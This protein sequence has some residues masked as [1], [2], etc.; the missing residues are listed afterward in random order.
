MGRDEELKLFMYNGNL[1][2]DIHRKIKIIDV[3]DD[4]KIIEEVKSRLDRRNGLLTN[5]QCAP[6]YYFADL[7]GNKISD[8]YYSIRQIG[9][10]K[11]F[12]VSELDFLYSCGLEEWESVG[13]EP[14]LANFYKKNPG[15]ELPR[16]FDFHYGVVSVAN[17]KVT[18]VVPVVYDRLSEDNSN[19]IIAYMN[20]DKRQKGIKRDRLGS[21]D[22]DPNSETYGMNLFPC[23]LTSLENFDLTY[24]GFARC[25]I[26]EYHGFISRKLDVNRFTELIEL[27]A[28]V[29][30]KEISYH[31]YCSLLGSVAQ[32]ALYT[33][34]EVIAQIANGE[35]EVKKLIKTEKHNSIKNSNEDE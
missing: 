3:F 30:N 21:I 16:Y 34:E 28:Q 11:H 27:Y 35:T 8:S 26:D 23:I 24:E 13:K 4:F 1:I 9:N 15:S 7:E 6:T 29:R 5:D 32:K 2:K 25:S 20:E 14:D 17:N 10:T 18:K 33:E 22:I 31:D 12:I 19:T